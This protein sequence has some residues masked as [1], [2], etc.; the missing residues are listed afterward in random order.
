MTNM[1]TK[2]RSWGRIEG[3]G[4]RGRGA[5]KLG[6]LNKKNEEKTNTEDFMAVLRTL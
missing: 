2:L 1:L 4:E 6:W 3:E 5:E